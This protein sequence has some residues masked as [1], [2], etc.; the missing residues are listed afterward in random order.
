[1]GTSIVLVPEDTSYGTE[2][3][4]V[5]VPARE[6]EYEISHALRTRAL[7]SLARKQYSYSYR[8]DQKLIP[9]RDDVNP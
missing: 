9:H 2:V 6:Y 3:V 4:V 1:M 8:L 5:L 7:I